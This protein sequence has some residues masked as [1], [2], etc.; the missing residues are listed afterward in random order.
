MIDFNYENLTLARQYHGL[1]QKDLASLVD[2]AQSSLS[3]IEKGQ[4][5]PS[6]ETMS[7]LVSH[8]G[9]TTKFYESKNANVSA[10]S[11]HGYRKQASVPISKLAKNLFLLFLD[12]LLPSFVIIYEY[13]IP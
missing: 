1:S 13:I 11:F 9:F 6:D 7:K 4:L 3:K 10:L 2:I 5:I 8:L 12:I